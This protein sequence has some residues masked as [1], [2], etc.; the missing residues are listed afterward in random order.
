MTGHRGCN[1]KHDKCSDFAPQYNEYWDS[2]AQELGAG[3]DAILNGQAYDAIRHFPMNPGV[4]PMVYEIKADAYAE[5]PQFLRDTRISETVANV[6]QDYPRAKA[7][8]YR[9]FTPAEVS[10]G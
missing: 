1:L 5:F 8:G 2:Q 7:C 10:I 6:A 9:Y 3:A 4:K